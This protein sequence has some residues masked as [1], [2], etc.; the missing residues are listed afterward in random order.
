MLQSFPILRF[1]LSIVI[2]ILTKITQCWKLFF[3]IKKQTMIGISHKNFCF[4]MIHTLKLPLHQPIQISFSSGSVVPNMR[5]TK[6]LFYQGKQTRLLST[7]LSWCPI[8]TNQTRLSSTSEFGLSC[9]LSTN[10]TVIFDCLVCL[11]CCQPTQ[12]S[13]LT[14]WSVLLLPT[15][16]FDC[17]ICLVCYPPISPNYHHCFQKR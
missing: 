6:K 17:L 4:Y 13:Y 16:I 10:P 12:P 3:K 8:K 2:G 15:V 7:K 14:A 9:S 11:V 5:L 1:K